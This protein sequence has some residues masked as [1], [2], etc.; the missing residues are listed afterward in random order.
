MLKHLFQVLTAGVILAAFAENANAS[1][2]TVTSIG[3]GYDNVPM[4]LN[5]QTTPTE[6]YAVEILVNLGGAPYIAYCVDLF[7][8]IGFATYNTTVGD[9]S[10]YSHGGRLAW[11]YSTY[12]PG[13]TTNDE[14]A[15]IQLALWDIVHDDGDG[16][17]AG[18]I[19]VAPTYST[20][21]I[22]RANDIIAASLGQSS[23]NASFLHN[24]SLS[25]GAPA[26][27]LITAY[28]AQVPEP[29]TTALIGLGGTLTMFGWFRRK[30]QK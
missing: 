10:T 8:E 4:L 26:Q 25:T 3:Y 1:T 30:K 21:V 15:A 7:T 14:A 29:S 27:T 18:N 22:T 12:A 9:V 13:V 5:G 16:L 2:I 20:T 24:A 19:Q 23:T 28:A 17:S 6:E 11:V